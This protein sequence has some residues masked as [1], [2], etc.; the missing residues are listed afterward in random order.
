MNEVI[1]AYVNMPL[2]DVY[3]RASEQP[4]KKKKNGKRKK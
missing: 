4:K 1:E 3:T 2:K